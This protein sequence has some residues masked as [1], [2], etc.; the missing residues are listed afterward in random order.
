MS[1]FY[2]K[3]APWKTLE[4]AF[5]AHTIDELKT[6]AT[7]LPGPS[8]LGNG[9]A[10]APCSEMGRSMGSTYSSGGQSAENRASRAP[11]PSV[12]SA[13]RRQLEAMLRMTSR[14]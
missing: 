10:S 3:F 4:Q 5:W 9:D 13:V 1:A 2:P 12:L 7:A 8:G 11:A 14:R 6:L